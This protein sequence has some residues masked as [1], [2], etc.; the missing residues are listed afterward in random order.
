MIPTSLHLVEPPKDLLH[1]M[2]S[3]TVAVRPFPHSIRNRSL[4]QSWGNRTP[5]DLSPTDPSLVE[6]AVFR[7]TV[8]LFLIGVCVCNRKVSVQGW[9]PTMPAS[10]V[11]IGISEVDPTGLEPVKMLRCRRSAV[12]L[13]PRAHVLSGI[14]PERMSSI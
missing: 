12:P 13:K 10:R 9:F 6:P 7:L 2:A 11:T 8:L 14:A 3:D 4:L 5:H 1:R